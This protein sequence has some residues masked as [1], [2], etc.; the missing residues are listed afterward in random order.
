MKCNICEDKQGEV[1]VLNAEG[2]VMLIC[3][4]CADKQD[5]T[6]LQKEAGEAALY[7]QTRSGSEC[8]PDWF[9]SDK[10]TQILVCEVS[11][12]RR[13]KENGTNK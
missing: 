6:L 12:E 10:S 13:W 5:E 8:S 2:D 11:I 7:S 1:S 9:D 3:V 4:E